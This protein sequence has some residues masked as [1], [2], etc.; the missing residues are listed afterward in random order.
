[1]KALSKENTPLNGVS[2]DLNNNAV[3]KDDNKELNKEP[4]E[5][6]VARLT[7]ISRKRI[8]QRRVKGLYSAS[9][10]HH[11]LSPMTY[12]HVQPTN[13]KTVSPEVLRRFSKALDEINKK[14][15]SQNLVWKS[16]L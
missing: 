3:D 13:D 1:M 7:Q 2:A 16:L 4:V 6:P 5:E 15:H 11:K 14:I 12:P 8:F 10:G 9:K